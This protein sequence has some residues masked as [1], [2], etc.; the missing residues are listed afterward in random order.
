M[1]MP[2]TDKIK[3]VAGSAIVGAI[4]VMI[5]GFSWGGWVLGSTAMKSGT[6][7]AQEAVIQRL[8]P[9]CL[10]Q[11]KQDP[12]KEDKFNMMK[13]KYD[14]DKEK[15]IREQGW[16]TMPFEEEPDDNVAVLCSKLI[17]EARQ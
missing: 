3:T 9:M 16:A 1:K 10:A 8:A 6:A 2:N 17:T 11:F 4:L 12:E 15:F 14:W 7:M 13:D 5:I